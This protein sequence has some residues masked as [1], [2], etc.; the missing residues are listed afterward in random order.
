MDLN[1]I[2][3]RLAVKEIVA[4]LSG[5]LAMEFSTQKALDDYLKA[6]PAADRSLHWVTHDTA[7]KQRAI[8]RETQVVHMVKKEAER[9]WEIAE[10]EVEDFSSGVGENIRSVFSAIP[11]ISPAVQKAVAEPSKSKKARESKAAKSA[12]TAARKELKAKL[13][14]SL[15]GKPVVKNIAKRL[16]HR[17]PIARRLV[18]RS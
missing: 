16:K 15:T 14:E 4:R 3:R 6:H 10:Q 12:R 2:A 5:R 11:R 9:A 7:G 18:N 8:Q 17:W 1:K 13:K